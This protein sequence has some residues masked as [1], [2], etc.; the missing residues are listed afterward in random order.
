[1]NKSFLQKIT[2]KL[3]KEKKELESGLTRIAKKDPKL[4]D[5]YD[6][7]FEDLGNEVYD[8][9]AEATEV[10][11]Y[12]MRLS[13]EGNLEVRLRDVKNALAQ[14]KAGTYGK[15][16]KCGKEIDEKR[17]EA[18]PTATECCHGECGRK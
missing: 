6:A 15:C 16:A 7:K 9:S 10:G 8:A 18:M 4:K 13:L 17:L 2:K 1:M 14:I 12:E 5:D 11:E 3:E